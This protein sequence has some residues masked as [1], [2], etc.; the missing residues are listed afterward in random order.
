[1]FIDH[2]M[3]SPTLSWQGWEGGRG[4]VKDG[5]KGHNL[6]ANKRICSEA[7]NWLKTLSDLLS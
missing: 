4:F 2:L 5:K 3:R 7:P 6:Q 1:M